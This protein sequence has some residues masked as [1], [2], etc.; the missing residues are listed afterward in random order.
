MTVT[1]D[2]FPK[3]AKIGPDSLIVN[4]IG[5]TVSIARRLG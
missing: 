5:D 1:N 4:S 2:P 3:V